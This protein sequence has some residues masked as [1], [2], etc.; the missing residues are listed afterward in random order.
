[1]GHWQKQTE[2]WVEPVHL[3]R[4]IPKDH[5]LRKIS[6]ALELSFVRAEVAGFYG[7]NGNVSVD[8]VIIVKPML[9]L[10]LDDIPSERELM[11]I[12]PLSLGL[13]LVPRFRAGG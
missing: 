10:F 6:K 7:S 2:L 5:L 3:G 8:P 12:V 13:S 11:R 1:M 4:R 9:L